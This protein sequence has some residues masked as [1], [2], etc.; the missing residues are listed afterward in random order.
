VIVAAV[1]FYGLSRRQVPSQ[2]PRAESA[3]ES[4][5]QVATLA[6]ENEDGGFHVGICTVLGSTAV[7]TAEHVV[8]DAAQVNA[9]FPEGRV[10]LTKVAAWDPV[11]HIVI[12]TSEPMLPI[13]WERLEPIYRTRPLDSGQRVLVCLPPDE[14]LQK[15]PQW[16]EGELASFTFDPETGLR[17]SLHCEGGPGQS[18]SPL[19]DEWGLVRGFVQTGIAPREAQGYIPAGV[20]KLQVYASPMPLAEWNTVVRELRGPNLEYSGAEYERSSDKQSMYERLK[21]DA[22]AYSWSRTR[23]DDLAYIA[24]QEGDA[25]EYVHALERVAILDPGDYRVRLSLSDALQGQGDARHAAEVLPVAHGQRFEPMSYGVLRSRWNCAMN[26]AELRD[27]AFVDQVRILVSYN[28][29]PRATVLSVAVECAAGRP[30]AALAR[31]KSRITISSLIAE[32][33]CL[34]RTILMCAV[35]T[36]RVGF[37]SISESLLDL[38]NEGGASVAQLGFTAQLCEAA[39]DAPAEQG[40]DP[41]LDPDELVEQLLH[42][43]TSACFTE[44][45]AGLWRAV[46][47]LRRPEAGSVSAGNVGADDVWRRIDQLAR[48]IHDVEHDA[49]LE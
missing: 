19:V 14:D 46:T 47:G 27:L 10:P 35:A 25:S 5:P 44:S 18:G 31:I 7:V 22:D 41:P 6:A 26:D 3:F 38:A 45:E 24:M 4:L 43:D 1:V 8:Y 32:E 17:F 23:W 20:S 28:H 12:L 49:D 36:R 33:E 48:D 11:G 15:V 40:S 21:T 9:L 13:E 34:A 30:E 37:D 39:R 29:D 42:G 16:T 2:S